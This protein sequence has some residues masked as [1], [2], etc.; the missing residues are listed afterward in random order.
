MKRMNWISFA[1]AIITVCVLLSACSSSDQ[2]TG[3]K[4]RSTINYEKYT[5]LQPNDNRTVTIPTEGIPETATFFNYDVDGVT[6]QLVALRD[7]NNGVHIAFNT[8]QSCSPSPKAYYQQ[9][10]DVLQCT[11]CGFTFTPEE[12]GIKAGGCN[13]WPI[14]GVS[15][16][17]DE[18]TIPV[19][20][21]EA[22]KSTFANWAG[23]VK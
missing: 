2:P 1:L 12:V 4:P 7:Q 16:D 17:D 9:S 23:P 21:L 11:N 15:T 18:I 20:S 22:M 13:P 3:E 8:C 19:S 10:G 6:V 5:E 14:D